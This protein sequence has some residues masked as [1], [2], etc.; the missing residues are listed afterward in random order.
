[1]L[2]RI[3]N[4]LLTG[5]LIALPLTVTVFVVVVLINNIGTP[6]SKI[7]FVPVFSLFDANF[8]ASGFGKMMLDVCATLIVLVIITVL[9][10]L[11]Q[12]FLGKMLIRVFETLI[13]KIP[14]AGLIYRTVKQIVDT[15]S[16][17]QKAVFQ[18][19]V[20]LEF[21]KPGLYAVGFMTSTAKGEIQAR[22]G[23]EVVNVFV[24]TTPNPTSGFLVMAPVN[25]I[26]KL[27]MSVGDAMKLIISGG[28]VIPEWNK[29]P[30]TIEK[31]GGAPKEH[32]S[33]TC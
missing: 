27:D 2:K 22:T 17:Q 1:M 7:F 26:V 23:E 14:V 25:K 24:P 13:N 10:F 9:G 4:F 8:P 15:F 31:L 18:E 16:K 11:S 21:P 30:N 12:F 3:G 32:H 33:Q 28:A 5:T 20:L 6:V 29:D 19:V